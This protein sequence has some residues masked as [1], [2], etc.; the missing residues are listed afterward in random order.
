MS[1]YLPTYEGLRARL[2]AHPLDDL[3]E[4][5]G[6]ERLGDDRIGLR[7]AGRTYQI[8]YPD[9]TVL[10]ADGAP[11]DVNVSILLLLY[12]MEATGRAHDG[13]WISF[14]QLPGGAGYL[15][16]FRGR[17]VQPALR[18]FGPRPERLMD[19]ARILGGEPLALGDVAARIPALPRVSMAYIVWR[20]DDEFPPS[21]SVVFD[22]SVEGYLDAEVLTALA[23]LTS[24]RLIAA[25]D[26]PKEG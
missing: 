22:A 4:R 6:A 18:A 7:C 26:A 25:A 14:E 10:Q 1:I 19:A 24:R 8:L 15:A 3:I 17:V 13:Q 23:E 9:G 11:A 21:L 12:L 5:S 20:G 16:S 2:A